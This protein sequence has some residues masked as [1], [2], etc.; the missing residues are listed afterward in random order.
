MTANRAGLIAAFAVGSVFTTGANA[1]ATPQ[2]CDADGNC[3]VRMTAEELLGAAEKLVH[4]RRFAEAAPMLAALE[5]APQLS[6][7]RQFLTGYSAIEQGDLDTAVKHFRAALVNN[8]EQTRI[9]LEL[10]RALMMQGKNASADHHFRLAGQTKDLPEDVLQTIRASRGIL[11]N[12][13]QWNFN[14]DFGFAPDSNI[15]NGTSA[16]TVDANFGNQ[17]IPLELSPESRKRSGIGQTA[18]LGSSAK[19]SLAGPTKLVI[20]SEAQLINY[21]GKKFDDFS[22][23]LAIGPSFKLSDTTDLTLQAMGSQRYYGGQRAATSFGARTSLQINV[24]N[25]QRIGLSVDGRHTNSGFANLYTGWQLGAYASYERVVA[26]SLIASAS[27]FA[28]RDLFNSKAY[29]SAEFGANLGIGGDLPKG[30]TAGIS[31]GVSRAVFDAPLPVFS[32]KPREDLRFN[33]RATVGLRKLRW[34]G[35]SPSVT[36]SYTKSAS[37]LPLYDSARKRVAFSFA[38]YF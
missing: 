31:A 10:A 22:G 12:E 5:N 28:R 19:L 9:R 13:K 23:Q 26:R 11:R 18:S 6:M 17:T 4:E 37:S 38:R 25:S 33:A 21:K 7:Q 29:S 35:F 15:S 34:L 32:L 36:F 14:F 16:T 3:K 2:T 20:D 1:Q 27:V 30:I 24:G 8:P